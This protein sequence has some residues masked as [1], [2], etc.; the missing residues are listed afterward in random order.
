MTIY[1]KMMRSNIAM[2]IPHRLTSAC[3]SMGA[4]L[5]SIEMYNKLSNPRTAWSK[6]SNPRVNKFSKVM[7][8]SLLLV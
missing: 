5:D 4:L 8:A 1:N 2:L 3:F 7:K 6:V